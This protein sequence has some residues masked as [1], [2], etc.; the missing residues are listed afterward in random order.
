MNQP[1]ELLPLPL[2]HS[3]SVDHEDEQN[4]RISVVHNHVRGAVDYIQRERDC[5]DGEYNE[6][7]RTFDDQL[8]LV[9]VANVYACHGV[10]PS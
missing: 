3:D 2:H 4:R 10:R 9:G 6:L 7:A 5:G 8:C 1:A